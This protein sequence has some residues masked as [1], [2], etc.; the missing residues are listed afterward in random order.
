MIKK[1]RNIV[2]LSCGVGVSLYPF[3]SDSQVIANVETRA[4]FYLQGS[5]EQFRLNFPGGVM[6]SDPQ[7]YKGLLNRTDIVMSQPKCGNSSVLAYSRGKKMTSHKGDPSLDLAMEGI[8]YLDPKVFL[9]EN[10]P[11]LLNTYSEKDLRQFF[12]HHRLHFHHVSVSEF[13]NS[14]KTRKRLVIV[15]VHRHLKRSGTIFK[16][17]G[18]VYPVKSLLHTGDLIYGTPENGHFR[19]SFDERIALYGGRQA[20]YREIMELWEELP[21][22][23]RI[24]TPDENFNTAPG[25]YRDLADDYPAT[26]RKSNRCFG[27]HGLTYTPRERA[28]IQGIPDTFWIADPITHPKISP[29]TLFNKGCAAM[30]NTPPLEVAE[31]FRNALIKTQ[32]L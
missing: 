12:H 14:Q 26:I 4:D 29:K 18:E 5:P 8:K 19:P 15:G 28:R 16:E 9:L 30:A 20:S 13:G 2:G 32:F 27:P 7:G 17:L 6:W 31:W 3:L 25:V 11:A 10:L 23:K 24:A 1:K 21:G 22:K